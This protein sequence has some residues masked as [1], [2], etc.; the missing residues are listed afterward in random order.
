MEQPYPPPS[1][2]SGEASAMSV[3]SIDYDRGRD[4]ARLLFTSGKGGNFRAITPSSQVTLIDPKQVATI[5]PDDIPSHVPTGSD[6]GSCEASSMSVS[7]LDHDRF[8]SVSGNGGISPR[9]GDPTSRLNERYD[10]WASHRTHGNR[11]LQGLKSNFVCWSDGP[12]NQLMW[13]A[14]FVC[15]RTGE[16]FATGTLLSVPHPR[17][18]PP[19]WYGTKK[20]AIKAAAGRAEDCFEFRKDCHLVG[21][22]AA[23]PPYCQDE[24]YHQASCDASDQHLGVL[25]IPPFSSARTATKDSDSSKHGA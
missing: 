4:L 6:P 23:S 21:F 2:R 15:P 9:A 3:S 11:I 13:N 12:Q 20:M 18:L 10:Q 7:G 25:D 5:V 8:P 14:V 17:N 19:G 24:P 16:C 1:P 22:A